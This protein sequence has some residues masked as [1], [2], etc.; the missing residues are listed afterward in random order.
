[1]ISARVAPL[2]RVISSKIV[3]PL[4]SGRSETS[5]VRARLPA[6]LLGLAAF[7]GRAALDLPPLAVFRPPG[8][9]FFWEPPSFRRAY[10]GATCA[11]RSA[12]AAAW[13]VV[14]FLR[15]FPFCAGFAHND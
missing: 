13:A 11:P 10:S 3:A 2:G 15:L 12:T 8:A 4:L 14:R 7:F 6:F 1:M 5:F 9:P